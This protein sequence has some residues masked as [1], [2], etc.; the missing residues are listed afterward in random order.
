MKKCP[1]LDHE[2]HS[3][4]RAARLVLLTAVVALSAVGCGEDE[5]DAFAWEGVYTISSR[6]E[7]IGSCDMEGPEVA[8]PDGNTRFVVKRNRQSFLGHSFVQIMAGPC[9]DAQACANAASGDDLFGLGAAFSGI[10]V[11]GDQKQGDVYESHMYSASRDSQTNECSAVVTLA[12]LASPAEGQVRFERR[13][14]TD[15]TYP[16][17]TGDDGEPTCLDDGDGEEVVELAR[18]QGTCAELGVIVAANPEPVPAP[19]T[20]DDTNAP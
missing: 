8:D 15:V 19:Q 5:E 1:A 18:T 16:A 4:A 9:P 3:V 6:T 10:S 7:N 17:Y 2:I 12:T 14:Y 11:F 20:Q 13:V